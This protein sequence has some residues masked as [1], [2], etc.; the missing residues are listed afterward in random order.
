MDKKIIAI[1]AV[2]VIVIAG[3]AAFFMLNGDKNKDTNRNGE[4]SD[5][6]DET[7]YKGV[8]NVYGNANMDADIDSKDADFIKSIIDKKTSWN[9]T[10]NPF[11]DT[12]SDGVI[13]SKDLDQV[14]KLIKRTSGTVVRFVDGN[15]KISTATLPLSKI[16]MSGANG[17]ELI[18]LALG[19]TKNE[20][21]MYD[22][23]PNDPANP[24][25]LFQNFKGVTAVSNV[26]LADY[27]ATTSAGIPDAIIYNNYSDD[28]LTDEQ[29][30]KYADAGIAL[31]PSKSMEGSIGDFALALGYLFD[32]VDK[33]KAFSNW[34]NK[35]IDKIDEATAKIKK[36]DYPS[37]LYWY[38]G[39]AAAGTGSVYNE[40]LASMGATNIADWE[41]DY[42]VLNK[43][44][45]TWVLDYDPDYVFRTV[46]FF[47]YDTTEDALKTQFDNYGSMISQL[48]AYKEDRYVFVA[49]VL[50]QILRM[51]YLASY[52]HPTELG[53]DFG[54]ECHKELIQMYGIDYDVDKHPFIVDGKH[55]K[56]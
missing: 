13:D 43:D 39:Q 1:I 48:N 41:G 4:N 38:G 42:K 6:G 15:D 52:I 29:L 25:S 12:N 47:G 32:K 49:G 8:M 26:N 24:G 31:I 56:S 14:N 11:A 40:L 27:D 5:Y 7:M 50:P 33:A 53:A 16:V 10:A 2:A 46:G 35:V 22:V 3:A 51:A 54:N 45:C 44:N 19:F 23:S 9:K 36:S 30:K 21:L 20:V 17:P 37:V 18:C 55:W 28:S 34:C